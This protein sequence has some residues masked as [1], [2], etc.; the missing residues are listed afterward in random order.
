M[1]ITHDMIE[2][3]AWNDLSLRQQGLYLHLKSKYVRKTVRGQLISSNR[4]DIS[5]PKAEW[6]EL[7]GHGNTF[8]ADMKA[9]F[10]HGFIT[11][12]RS[13]KATR[14]CNLYGFSAEWQHW[15]P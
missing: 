4:D 2:S 7:Y 10:D 14:T 8:R 11:L 13:G 15:T 9:L 5:I 6:A 1:L 3:P 12:M